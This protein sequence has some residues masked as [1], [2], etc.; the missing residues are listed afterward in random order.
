MEKSEL[1]F[2]Y[3]DLIANAENRI[4]KLSELKEHLNSLISDTA[5]TELMICYRE[6]R[7]KVET[8]IGWDNEEAIRLKEEAKG[9]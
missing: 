8:F 7:N 3:G 2:V 4:K 9:I 6:L 5:D 1:K